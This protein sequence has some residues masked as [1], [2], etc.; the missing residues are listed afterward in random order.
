L[1][2]RHDGR[3]RSSRP[4]FAEGSSGVPGIGAGGIHRGTEPALQCL[5]FGRKA[6]RQYGRTA[7]EARVRS[8]S[9]E[10]AVQAETERWSGIRTRVR[11]IMSHLLYH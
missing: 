1:S 2:L 9:E 3:T 7:T 11:M 6:L 4:A 10:S 5:W 8:P